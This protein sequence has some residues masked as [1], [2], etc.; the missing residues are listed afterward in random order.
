VLV[1]LKGRQGRKREVL[2]KTVAGRTEEE[3]VL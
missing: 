1:S 3:E 2:K